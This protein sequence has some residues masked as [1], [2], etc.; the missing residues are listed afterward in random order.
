MILTDFLDRLKLEYYTLDQ[1]D[2][3][4]YYGRL[5]SLFVLL[6]LD[7]EHLDEEHELGITNLLDKFSD[8]NE[9]D[10]RTDL[11][12]GE[13]QVITLK[14]KAGLALIINAIEA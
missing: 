7:G 3:E 4:S 13:L 5:S 11:S 6:E 10:L 12:A 1:L 8:I 14:I 9:Q 2:L